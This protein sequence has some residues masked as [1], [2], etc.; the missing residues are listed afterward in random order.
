MNDA[1][2]PALGEIADE[3]LNRRGMVLRDARE[4]EFPRFGVH[5]YGRHAK[6][7]QKLDP[8]VVNLDVREE[9]AVDAAVTRQLP[10]ALQR[11]LRFFLHLQYKRVSASRQHR[12]HAADKRRGKTGPIQ[13]SSFLAG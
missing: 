11:F 12:L 6:L 10:V 3:R 13:E 2:V 7:L 8:R 1:F 4:R 5:A 9:H